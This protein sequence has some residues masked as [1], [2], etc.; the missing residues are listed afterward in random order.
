MQVTKC[1]YCGE[2]MEVA[3]LKVS[4]PGPPRRIS[5][6]HGPATEL[7]TGQVDLHI[8]VQK[9]KATHLPDI[10]YKCAAAKIADSLGMTLVPSEQPVAEKEKPW[11]MEL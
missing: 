1:D 6:I 7:E 9:A 10:C 11:D 5:D 4:I 8:N 3:L 2:E